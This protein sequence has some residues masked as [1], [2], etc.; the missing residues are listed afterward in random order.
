M[1]IEA[2]PYAVLGVSRECSAD[3]LKSA[4]RRL[5]RENHPDIALDKNAAT[6]RITQI[7][8]AWA[9]V[10]DPNK[11]ASFDA[12]WRLDQH[13]RQRQAAQRFARERSAPSHKPNPSPPASASSASKPTA[14]RSSASGSSGSSRSAPSKTPSPKPNSKPSPYRSSASNASRHVR[15]AEA[16]S[17]LFKQNK[18]NEALEICKSILKTDFRN[19]PARELMGEAY[20]RLGQTDRALA[21]WEQ[22]LVLSPSNVT[23]RRRWLSLMP[24]ET[25]ATY[26]RKGSHMAGAV[27][28]ATNVAVPANKPKRPPS[29]GLLS[30]L[31]SKLKKK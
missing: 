23:L 28:R 13:D 20:L 24:P 29:P 7:N 10:G 17:L 11:R 1:N 12:R 5:A 6:L 22:A 2:D 25:R 30:R 21:V 14:G 19:I 26:E 31:V 16:S 9:L 8:A 27:P 15:L 4:Y 18:P 3:E